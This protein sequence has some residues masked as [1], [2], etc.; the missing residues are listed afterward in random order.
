MTIRKRVWVGPQ[1]HDLIRELQVG[2]ALER[3]KKRKKISFIESGEKLAFLWKQRFVV[4]KER[5]FDEF[6]RL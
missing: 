4:Q 2:L 1:L 5:D 6:M 3:R